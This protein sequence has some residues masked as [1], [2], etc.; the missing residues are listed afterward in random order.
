MSEQPG[1][2]VGVSVRFIVFVEVG[3]GIAVGVIVA[4]SVGVTVG[5]KRSV[6]ESVD[7]G[8]A[9]G[10]GVVASIGVAMYTGVQVGGNG[11]VPGIVDTGVIVRGDFAMLVGVHE[12]V[13]SSVGTRVLVGVGD[14]VAVE[15]DAVASGGVTIGGVIIVP[16]FGDDDVSV[17]AAV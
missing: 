16:G 3:D 1:S 6:P 13:G 11:T 17:A 4:V 9:V 12:L 8:V 5:G 14:S 15:A 7:V 10:I 2:M